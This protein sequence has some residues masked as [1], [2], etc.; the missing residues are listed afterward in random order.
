MNEHPET[1]QGPVDP[2]G[3]GGADAPAPP[4]GPQRT[5]APSGTPE[6][7]ADDET[8]T[9]GHIAEPVGGSDA[10]QDDGSERQE[11]NAQTSLDQPSS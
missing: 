9:A 3:E 11:E 6:T 10:R 5:D 2:H 1:P 4:G 8:G 7:T